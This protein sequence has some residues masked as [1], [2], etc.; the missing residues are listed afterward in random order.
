MSRGK[1]FG[2]SPKKSEFVLSI[3][4]L[5]LLNS[6]GPPVVAKEFKDVPI[7]QNYNSEALIIQLKTSKSFPYF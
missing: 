5:F 3:Y 6:S 4:L 7:I 2:V 1:L